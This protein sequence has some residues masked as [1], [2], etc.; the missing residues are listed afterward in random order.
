MYQ[1]PR[2]QQRA[3]KPVSDLLT[4]GQLVAQSPAITRNT[5]GTYMA[6]MTYRG[7]DLQ[8][9]S[10]AE[11]GVYLHQLH[12]ALMRLGTGWA[13]LADSWSEPTTAYIE[14]TWQQ[15]TSAFVDAA[16]RTQY[17]Q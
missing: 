12:R 15:P 5:D 6:A 3:V 11:T 16:R 10:E 1:V 2:A 14:S 8:M 9:L 13:L 7:H 4:W 17:A